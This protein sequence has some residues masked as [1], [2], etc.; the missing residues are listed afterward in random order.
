[1]VSAGPKPHAVLRPGSRLWPVFCLLRDRGPYGATTLE[2][3]EI[4]AAEGWT[5]FNISSSLSDIRKVCGPHGYMMPEAVQEGSRQVG[6]RKRKLFRY[7]LV[8]LD[9]VQPLPAGP[10]LASATQPVVAM[11]SSRPGSA[12]AALQ[13]DL[14]GNSGRVKW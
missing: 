5:D 13:G 7:H 8:K 2:L 1:M 3:S 6:S 9:S 12:P 10:A 11:A 14:F 4:M